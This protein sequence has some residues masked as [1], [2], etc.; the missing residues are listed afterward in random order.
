MWNLDL[1]GKNRTRKRRCLSGV[2]TLCRIVLLQLLTVALNCGS[3]AQNYQSGETET[4][5][6]ET[7]TQLPPKLVSNIRLQS[8]K[9]VRNEPGVQISW[10]ASEQSTEYEIWRGL[11]PDARDAV[12][13]MKDKSASGAF[14]DSPAPVDT[15][16]YYWIRAVTP[17]GTGPFSG[18]IRIRLEA[19]EV[20]A[21]VLFQPVWKSGNYPDF[22]F[23]ALLSWLEVKNASAYEVWHG[24]NPVISEND[25]T[26]KVMSPTS[27]ISIPVPADGNEFYFA[28]RTITPAGMSPY[29]PF[30]KAALPT[31]P[32]NPGDS[33]TLPG[34]N[35]HLIWNSPGEVVLGSNRPFRDIDENEKTI[36]NLTTGFWI[37]AREVTIQQ[38]LYYLQSLPES[39]PDVTNTKRWL[40][41]STENPGPVL[42]PGYDPGDPVSEVTW[43][44]S[45]RFLDWITQIEASAGRLP[46][47]YVY[48]LPTEAE[49]IYA[50]TA[51]KSRSYEF[52]SSNMGNT[53]QIFRSYQEFVR[54]NYA[55][56]DANSNGMSHP[57]ASKEPDSAGLYDILGNV[58][59]WTQDWYAK[60][61]G[62]IVNDWHGPENGEVKPILGGHYL[63]PAHHLSPRKRNA[64]KPS[65]RSKTVGFR[66][67]LA[68]KIR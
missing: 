36:V 52:A 66:I 8:S 20:S 48:R 41:V 22:E 24:S 7:S 1:D 49:W 46:E 39:H 43:M 59:E 65:M 67:V 44:E 32:G 61:P 42:S 56:F 27:Y 10:E 19:P 47:G 57:T 53:L 54:Q 38:F 35:F 45:Q 9:S 63:S 17:Q 26:V 68:P 21:P 23:R 62:G 33:W 11:V 16:L 14:L 4:T 60:Y 15:D 28:V 6:E 30:L 31:W 2:G 12:L 64:M 25:T 37:G 34:I 5:T 51:S 50:A 40:R 55:W 18:G 29:S 13:L 3:L 58:A